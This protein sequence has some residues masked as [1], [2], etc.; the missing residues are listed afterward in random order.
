[1]IPSVPNPILYLDYQPDEG[2]MIRWLHQIRRHALVPGSHY[3]V[4]AIMMMKVD[5]GFYFSCGVNIESIEQRLSLHAEESAIAVLVTAFGK[6]AVIDAVWLMAAP[7]YLAGPTK[8]PMADIKGQACG[9][10]RQQIAGLAA[11]AQIPVCTF[12]L[13]GA[14]ETDSIDALLPKSFSFADF[15]PQIAAQ[16]MKDRQSCP[17]LD[18]GGVLRRLVRK[19]PQTSADIFHWLSDLQAVDYASGR[20]QAA[21]LRLDSGVYVAGVS[22]ENAA[23]AGLNSIQSALAVAGAAFGSIRVLDVHLFCGLHPPSLAALQILGEFL[24]L[25][26]IDN[27]T[28]TLYDEKTGDCAVQPLRNMANYFPVRSSSALEIVAGDVPGSFVLQPDDL[29]WALEKKSRD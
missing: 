24:D 11:H 10:C 3:Q 16:R 8:D 29:A 13:N 27:I 1:M 5:G 17:S 15:D 18:P 12:T 20:P 21:V 22:V 2:V 26:K 14:G 9:N 4:G 25:D 19:T 28:A 6:S 7:E 23:Y